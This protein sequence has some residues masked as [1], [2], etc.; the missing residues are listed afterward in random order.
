MSNDRVGTVCSRLRRDRNGLDAP[1]LRPS[2]VAANPD[3]RQARPAA[4]PDSVSARPPSRLFASGPAQ[5]APDPAPRATSRSKTRDQD[6]SRSQARRHARGDEG[7]GCGRVHRPVSGSPL[8]RVRPDVLRAK[9]VHQRI[10]PAARTALVTHDEALLWTDGRYF[11]QAEQELGPEWTLM[12]GGSPAS[13]SLRG[14]SPAMMAKWI[15]G[16]RRPRGALPLRGSSPPIRPGGRRERPGHPR[17]QSG[18]HGVGRGST[19]LSPPRR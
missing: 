6:G 15:Q 10:P 2:P 9:E 12:R 14:F 7:R 13:P 11:L 19:G 8:Q 1:S 5:F 4:D 16:W 17:R 18:G 3:R